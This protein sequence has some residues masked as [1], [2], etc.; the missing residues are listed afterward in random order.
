MSDPKPPIIDEKPPIIDPKPPGPDAGLPQPPLIEQP[1]PDPDTEKPAVDAYEYKAVTIVGAPA[2]DT[3]EDT[4]NPLGAEGWLVVG[5]VG[6]V[7][8]LY[9][10][11]TTISPTSQTKPPYPQP[12][13]YYGR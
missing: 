6:Q 11:L 3:V 1:P 9:R 12:P 5:I 10:P 7:V 2:T 13:F 8:I 4:L